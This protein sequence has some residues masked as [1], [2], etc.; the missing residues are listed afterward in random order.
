MYQPSILRSQRMDV[1]FIHLTFITFP[2]CAT[3]SVRVPSVFPCLLSRLNQTLNFTSSDMH[4][5]WICYIIFLSCTCR[6]LEGRRKQDKN[7]KKYSTRKVNRFFRETETVLQNGE[8]AFI[9]SISVLF[10]FGALFL[11]AKPQ[12]QTGKNPTQS[13]NTVPGFVNSGQGQNLP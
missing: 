5:K 9:W 1:L 3:Y 8:D 12:K 10:L 2:L 11:Y 7:F 13:D 6:K 4:H